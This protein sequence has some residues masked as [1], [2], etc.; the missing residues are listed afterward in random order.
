MGDNACFITQKTINCIGALYPH[1]VESSPSPGLLKEEP[2]PLW[3]VF[4][5]SLCQYL[6][7]G[8]CI[9]HFLFGGVAVSPFLVDDEKNVNCQSLIES[10][11]L[12]HGLYFIYLFWVLRRF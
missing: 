5:Q 7:P 8:F 1:K 2:D 11:V 10:R 9:R 4:L 6:V 3:D 12:I